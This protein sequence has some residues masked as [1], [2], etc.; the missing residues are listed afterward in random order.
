LGAGIIFYNLTPSFHLQIF[1]VAGARVFDYSGA[2]R[3]G[4]PGTTASCYLWDTG[5]S[6]GPAGSGVYAF[7]AYDGSG[8]LLGRGKFSIIR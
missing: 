2:S 5:T 1:N 7:R 3:T 4:C 6:G 8:G